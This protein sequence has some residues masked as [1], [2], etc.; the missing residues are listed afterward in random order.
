MN[1]LDA[2]LFIVGFAAIIAAAYFATGFLG[3]RAMRTRQAREIKILDRFALSKDK[4][5]YLAQVRDKVYFIALTHQSAALFDTFEAEAFADS[6][7][8]RMT[9]REALA[10]SAT[11]GGAP[12]WLRKAVSAGL[13][14]SAVK[15]GAK[16]G[17]AEANAETD[18]SMD[19]DNSDGEET[20]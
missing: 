1:A 11:A 8:K 18:T 20:K 2:I 12:G 15:R 3:S 9:F 5:L 16:D 7:P 13:S 4:S 19:A 14:A 10:A 6:A 17:G